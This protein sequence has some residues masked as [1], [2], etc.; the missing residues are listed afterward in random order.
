MGPATGNAL[1]EREQFP[2]RRARRQAERQFWAITR[3][4]LLDCGFS[5]ART[6][7]WLR[8]GRLHRRYPGVYA[9]GRPELPEKGELAA[10]LLYAGH[11]SAL[12]GISM[13]WW[14]GLL[15]HRPRLIEI[16]A[17]GHASS[18]QDLRIRHPARITRR[19]H[20]GIPVVAL[21]EALLAAAADLSHDAMRNVL[22]RADFEGLLDLRSLQAALRCGPKGGAAL[23]RAIGA[24]LPQLARCVNDFERDFVLL[25]EEHR[26]PI[27][28]PNVRKGR[29]VP[30]MTWEPRRLIAELDGRDAH[31]SPAQLA[32]DATKQRWL[33]R[34]G[35]T[36]I[37]FRWREV[38][39]ERGSVAARVGAALG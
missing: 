18:R 38:Y 11:G 33:E 7:R 36:V 9:W 17:P 2:V 13:L 4:Q 23:R 29:Y 5:S 30:D 22:A 1:D 19:P 32:K 15:H 21:P 20:D 37:R 28:E 8:A 35:Y 25:C 24:H 27:P 34:A 14:L 12:G 31:T 3:R 6:A 16:D 39:F 26:L 10:G